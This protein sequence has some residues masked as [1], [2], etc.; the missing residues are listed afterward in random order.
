[1]KLKLPITAALAAAVL[2]LL[3][4]GLSVQAADGLFTAAELDDGTVSIVCSDKSVLHAEI[5]AEI[6]GRPVSELGEGC[7]DGC[8]SLETVSIPDTVTAIR[9]YAFQGCSMLDTVE[10]PAS[11]VEIG[12]FVFEGCTSLAEIVTDTDNREYLSED[13]ILFTKEQDTLLRF[14]AAAKITDYTLPESCV[15]VAPWAFTQCR[16][17]EHVELPEVIAMGADAF[18]GCTA[19]ESVVLSDSITELIGATFANCTGLVDVELPSHLA[20]LGDKCFFGCVHLYGVKFPDTLKS[21]GEQAYFGCIAIQ[22]MTLPAGVKKIGEQ[23]IGYSLDSDQKPVVIPD[24]HVNVTFGT[25]AHKYV[26]ANK[27]PYTATISRN[28]AMLVLISGILLLLLAVGI[29][30]E[31][32]RRKLQKAEEAARLEEER[33]AQALAERRAKKRSKK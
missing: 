18:M 33:R 15:T 8:S 25:A 19:L 28:T 3:L 11:V 24:L 6:D 26:K 16:Y 17:L 4:P 23:G 14:P 2:C 21:I 1:M 9:N 20:S 13:G 32:K 10:I 30:V 27:I 12:D 7:F 29:V 22:E 31:V 5:P